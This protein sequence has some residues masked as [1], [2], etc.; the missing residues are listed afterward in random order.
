MSDDRKAILDLL[1]DLHKKQDHQSEK[2]HTIDINYTKL[3]STIEN[4]L[5]QENTIAKHIDSID[6]R[7]AEY[8]QQLAIHIAGVQELKKITATTDIKV[9]TLDQRVEVL[10]APRKAMK[11]F[12]KFM[13]EIGKLAV[14][15]AAIYAFLKLIFPHM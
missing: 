8:N 4:H 7:L 14:A 6:A 11:S 12:K 9:V 2:L 13:I 3:N 10:E 5:S 15:A 1:L